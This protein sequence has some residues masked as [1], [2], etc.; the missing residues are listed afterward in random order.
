MVVVLHTMFMLLKKTSL[1]FLLTLSF[2]QAQNQFYLSSSNGN[3][4]NDG[5]A[6]QPWQTLEKISNTDL[7]PGDSVYFLKGDSFYGHFVVNGSGVEGNPITITSYGSGDK[8]I[9]SGAVGQS[10]GGDFQEAILINNNDN[11]IFDG[12]EVQNHRSVSRNNVDDLVSFGIHVIND[13]NYQ[14]MHNFT[15]RNMT[16]RNVYALYWVDPSNQDEFNQF[17]VSGVTFSSP[18]GNKNNNSNLQNHINN[19]LIEDCYFTDLQRLGVHI[20]NI[21]PGNSNYRNTNIIVRQNEFYQIGGTCVLPTRA[22]NCL[23]ENNIFDQPGAKTNDKMIGRG[24][25]VWN[26][27]CI[28][29]VVQNNQCLNAKGILDSHGIHV[30]HRN[31]DTFIQYNYME[32]CEGGF[33]EILG[34][35]ERAVY[36]FNISVN[37][38]WR[39]NP[40][41]ENSDHTIWLNNKVGN[42]AGFESND[43]YI[44]NNTIIINKSGSEAFETAIDIKA[45]NTRLFNNIFYAINGSGIGTQFLNN[46]DTNLRMS[47][48][49]FYG[50]V[51]N[52]FINE[53]LNPLRNANPE[54]QNET[55]EHGLGFQISASSPAIDAGRAYIGLYSHP[56]IPVEASTIFSNVEAIPSFDFFG[57]SIAG[58]DSPNAG[59]CNAKNGE[60]LSSNGLESQQKIR[61]QSSF[62]FDKIILEGVDNLYNYALIDML[63]RVQQKGVIKSDLATIAIAET[64]KTGIYY[65]VLKSGSI[66]TSLKLLK[67]N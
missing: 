67:T 15:L 37:D 22:E 51:R 64:L 27:Y 46:D 65:L 26:W 9:I 40:N 54:F 66:S 57:N 30:D 50:D 39:V 48:N 49:L 29:T 10:G 7:G 35:N 55:L 28:N 3:D 31:V 45:N 6:S 59:A 18:R 44:Y 24:S 4:S 23:I 33:V 2:L 5:S 53:D 60:T 17:K 47:H 11:I 52:S 32:D 16:F 56:A 43:S 14:V 21:A 63:G 61:L 25:A 12:L 62:V 41:W 42:V 13:S 1:L 20:S 58:D 19:I 8:P 34:D 38:G 36:R